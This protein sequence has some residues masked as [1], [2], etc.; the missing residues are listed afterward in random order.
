VERAANGH[1]LVTGDLTIR[2]VTRE[3]VLSVEGLAPAVK[4]P[5][6][7]TKSGATATTKIDRKD[8]G[9]SWNALMDNGGL[10]VGNEVAIT[11]DVELVRKNASGTAKSE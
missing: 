3:V 10:V 1:L 5:W 9:V 2:G 7:N 11:I 4:D 8:F 6:G